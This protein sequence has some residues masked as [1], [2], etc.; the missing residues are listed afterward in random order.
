MDNTNNNSTKKYSYQKEQ[1]RKKPYF[2]EKEQPKKKTYSYEKEQPRKKPYF[3]EKD[4]Q[5]E[6]KANKK[7]IF[8]WII[9]LAA[10]V[11]GLC[12]WFFR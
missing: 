7:S 8:P 3:Y 1:T 5:K 4:L 9:I 12:F 2:Y 11:A 10:I 6:A